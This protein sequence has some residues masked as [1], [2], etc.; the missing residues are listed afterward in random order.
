MSNI[1]IKFS[2][3]SSELSLPQVSIGKKTLGITVAGDVQSAVLNHWR[4]MLCKR[5]FAM[6]FC[7]RN[8]GNVCQE[9]SQK[10]R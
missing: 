9:V 10:G 3:L 7:S 8:V 5:L 4:H 6:G 2:L 1:E